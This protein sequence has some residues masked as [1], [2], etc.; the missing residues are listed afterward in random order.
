M[1]HPSY[2]IAAIAVACILAACSGPGASSSPAGEIHGRVLAGP[3]CPVVT[4]PPDPSCR[5]RPVAGAVILVLD[6]AG[7]QVNRATSGQDGR[8]TVRLVP[9][10]YRLVPQPVEG[11]MGTAEEQEV[12]VTGSQPTAEVIVAYDTG[13]R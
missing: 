7:A 3:T 4:D 6:Q 12:R 9:G 1:G 10:T 2:G 11:L 5:D 13:I 8:F